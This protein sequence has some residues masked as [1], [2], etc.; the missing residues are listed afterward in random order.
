MRRSDTAIIDFMNRALIATSLAAFLLLAAC[1][2]DIQTT[3]A[4]QRGVM[5]YL[6]TKSGLSASSMDVSVTSV[7]FRQNEA[8][9]VV[10]FQAKGSNDAASGISM[11]YVLERKGSEWVVKGRAGGMGNGANPHGAAASPHG[12]MGGMGMTP[13]PG[14]TPALPPGHPA[15]PSGG[16]TPAK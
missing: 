3:D 15:M 11:K 8:D 14:G 13:Q 2:K 4:V 16:G 7:S 9:A 5:N 12:D 1:H 6:A 10:H